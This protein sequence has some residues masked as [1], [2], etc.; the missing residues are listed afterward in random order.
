MIWNLIAIVAIIALDQ[1]TK[2][3]TV[4]YVEP[5][6]TIPLIQDAVHLTYV[7]N[8][9][10]AFSLLEGQVTLFVVITL[11]VIVALSFLLWKHGKVHPALRISLVMILGGAVGNL[12]DRVWLG[13]VRDMIDFRIINYAVFNVADCFVVVG[14][15][16]LALYILLWD[17]TLLS[18]SDKAERA[19]AEGEQPEETKHPE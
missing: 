10:A 8:R 11:A 13:Y 19:A 15:I 7:E 12:I 18:R 2:Y 17:R 14:T 9:G 6:G 5:V 4:A 16:L 3:L 1:W